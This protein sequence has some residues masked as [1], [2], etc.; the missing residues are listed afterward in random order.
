MLVTI[1]AD[2]TAAYLT[3][4]TRTLTRML[5]ALVLDHFHN[6]GP[7]SIFAGL[8]FLKARTSAATCQLQ[9]HFMKPSRNALSL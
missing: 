4:T 6:V 2:R 9:I 7:P 1:L 8:H 3:R 5:A